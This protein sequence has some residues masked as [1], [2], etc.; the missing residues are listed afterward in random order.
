MPA[1]SHRAPRLST[2]IAATGI[3]TASFGVPQA[4]ADN[5]PGDSAQSCVS[6][7]EDAQ[8]DRIG[9]DLL[10]A[11]DELRRCSASSCP[12]LIQNDCTTWLGQVVEMI[13]SVLFDAKVGD[14]NV[15]DVSVSLDGKVIATQLDGQRV[16]VDP[17][18]HTFVFERAGYPS[19]EKKMIVAPRLAQQVVAV[20]WRSAPAAAPAAA[21]TPGAAPPADSDHHGLSTGRIAGWTLLGV[22]VAGVAAGAATGILMFTERD[23]AH[24]ACP[25]NQCKPGGLDDI[26]RAKT[27]ATISTVAFS[28]G[29]AFAA[30]GLYFVLRPEATPQSAASLAIVPALSPRAGGLSLQGRFE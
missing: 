16:E 21:L 10:R 18:I 4:R 14:D 20:A 17:G 11:R 1:S 25:A 19:I 28:A 22:G 23:S 29:A 6:S 2:L 27:D 8:K 24:S 12:V 5:P 9:G 15:F 30:V 13:P 26:S 3:V 7:Y